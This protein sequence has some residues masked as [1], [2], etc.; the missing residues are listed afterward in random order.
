MHQLNAGDRKAC[1]PEALEAKH[2]IDLG[3]DVSMILLDQVV[4]VL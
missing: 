3:L 1:I 4:Q 2:R